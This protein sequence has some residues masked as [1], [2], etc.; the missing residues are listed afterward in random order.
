MSD[1][2]SGEVRVFAA[3]LGSAY[4][5]WSAGGPFIALLEDKQ[6][7]DMAHSN[8]DA[9]HGEV[10]LPND[11][12]DNAGLQWAAHGTWCL[13]PGS[14]TIFDASSRTRLKLSCQMLGETITATGS[15]HMHPSGHVVAEVM[16]ALVL[17]DVEVASLSSAPSTLSTKHRAIRHWEIDAKLQHCSVHLA[18]IFSLAPCA[19]SIAWTP[20]LKSSAHYVIPDSRTNL[21]L[22]DAHHHCQ[23]AKWTS[24]QLFRFSSNWERESSKLLWS[25]DGRSLACV[26]TFGFAVLTFA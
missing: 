4:A 18:G 2:L 16:R 1:L 17:K 19:Q 5:S 20:V 14:H 3:S 24:C 13:L 7:P 10:I 12:P 25:A 11:S 9:A 21:Y 6:L 15:C 23:L 8:V 26:L 22:M